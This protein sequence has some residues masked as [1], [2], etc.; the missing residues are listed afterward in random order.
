[1]T[2]ASPLTTA[3]AKLKFRIPTLVLPFV[4]SQKT[5]ATKWVQRKINTNCRTHSTTDRNPANRYISHEFLPNRTARA[6]R[7]V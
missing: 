5:R 1:M 2:A 3:I 4:R 7:M 6:L